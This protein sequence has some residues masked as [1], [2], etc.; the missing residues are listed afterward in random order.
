MSRFAKQAG[1][2]GTGILL[3]RLLPRIPNHF[4]PVALFGN[5]MTKLEQRI[6]RNTRNAGTIYTLT[7]I[8]AAIAA[9]QKLRST[10]AAVTIA[11]AGQQ[12]RQTATQVATHT[13][14]G[15]RSQT[16]RTRARSIA[17][18]SRPLRSASGIDCRIGTRGQS[19]RGCRGQSG[20][21][22]GCT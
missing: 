1:A 5:A 11:S 3:Q 13:T 14:A 12:L 20:G 6:Y 16:G 15:H 4:H 18:A 21:A 9:A 10:T 8:A 17:C 19:R 22:S 2:V 7:G